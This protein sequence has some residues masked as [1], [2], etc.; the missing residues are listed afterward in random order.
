M[1]SFRVAGVSLVLCIALSGCLQGTGTNQTTAAAPRGGDVVER[2]VEAPDVF[3][4]RDNALWD[5]RPSLGGV[6]VAHP[7]VKAPERVIIRN[8]ETGR[9]TVGALFKRERMNPG[10]VFQVSAETAEAV[11]M[12]AGAP[13]A[14]EVVALRTE[15][16]RTAPEAEPE[17]APQ[18]EPELGPETE[19][20]TASAPQAAPQNASA[21]E[22]AA[23]AT[24]APEETMIALPDVE[25]PRK[26]GL[27]ARIFGRDAPEQSEIT[28][29]PLDA[30]TPLP[31]A[32]APPARP[33]APM[34]MP[35]PIAGTT[36]AAPAASSLDRP[37][38]QIGIFSVEANAN[39]AA[40]SMRDAGLSASI[41][42]GRT[43]GNAF[44]RV[45]VGPAASEA[46]RR[47]FLAQVKRLGFADAYAVRR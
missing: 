21:P 45:V 37:F 32:A 30:T 1:F 35:S 3:S 42:P 11:G 13:T 20:E 16:V 34:P 8:T 26:R 33:G 39:G 36:P 14:L 43:Q 25:E 23:S 29:A 12:L 24:G 2:D 7:D 5:G 40:K 4:K 44:W 41:K 22:D 18:P 9:E 46:E 27:F 38:V 28:S 17:P 6:W 47:Q 15:E 10:P 19:P 31:D